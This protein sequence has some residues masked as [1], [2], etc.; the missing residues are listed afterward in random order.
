MHSASSAMNW[1]QPRDVHVDQLRAG[2]NSKNA[3][4]PGSNHVRG[5]NVLMADGSVVCLPA[6][7]SGNDLRGMATTAGNEYIEALDELDF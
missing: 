7:T 3:N 1:L 5:T 2:L 6:T 4:A